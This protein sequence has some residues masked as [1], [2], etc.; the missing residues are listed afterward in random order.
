[1]FLLIIMAPNGY[2][3]HSER[4]ERIF[5]HYRKPRG[6]QPTNGRPCTL[7]KRGIWDHP[8]SPWNPKHPEFDADC[9]FRYVG[10]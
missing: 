10:S 7:C 6:I 5:P 4:R 9:P 8:P 1:M 2:Y 3:S